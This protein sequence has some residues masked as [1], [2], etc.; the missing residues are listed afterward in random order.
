MVGAQNA[1]KIASIFFPCRKR[2]SEETTID[3]TTNS[4]MQFI[5]PILLIKSFNDICCC[6]SYGLKVLLITIGCLIL[7]GFF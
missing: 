6:Y 5:T 2:T 3:S 7:L 1:K 4:M